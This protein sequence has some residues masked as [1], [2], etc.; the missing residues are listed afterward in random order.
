MC[1]G[2]QNQLLSPGSMPEL[3]TLRSR[4]DMSVRV[5]F[6]Q[7]VDG[8]LLSTSRIWRHLSVTLSYIEG[9]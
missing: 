1:V 2:A 4:A 8:L 7:M 9:W 3:R 6:V 5:F